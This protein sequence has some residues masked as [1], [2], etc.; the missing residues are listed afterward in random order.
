MRR[1]HIVILAVLAWFVA[2]WYAFWA[3]AEAI[4]L[5]G[6]LLLGLAT[7]IL[8]GLLLK[9]LGQ[10][11]IAALRRNLDGGVLRESAVVDGTLTAIGAI[12]L[13]LPGFLSDVVGFVLAL[14]V[15]RQWLTGRLAPAPAFTAP[16]APKQPKVVDLSADL[17]KPVDEPR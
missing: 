16:R 5:G 13:I 17:W 14:P 6:A 10:D 15:I 8:G 12:L 9:K 1:K 2:E 3:V 4:G 11:T 7:S